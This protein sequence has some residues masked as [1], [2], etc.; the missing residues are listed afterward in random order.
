MGSINAVVL[1]SGCHIRL[2]IGV[3]P[4]YDCSQGTVIFIFIFFAGQYFSSCLFSFGGRY[5]FETKSQWVVL[6]GLELSMYTVLASNST[7]IY[8]T[9]WRAEIKGHVT[10]HAAVY[11]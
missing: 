2:V 5:L 10:K 7:E 8:T 4:A 6:A 3:F 9:L 1:Q 11:S